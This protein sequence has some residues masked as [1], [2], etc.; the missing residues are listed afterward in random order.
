[1]ILILLPV[2][3]TVGAPSSEQA[4]VPLVARTPEPSEWP[5]VEGRWAFVQVTAA[6]S[7]APLLGQLTTET[8]ARGLVE[9][10]RSGQD[11]TLRE[12]VCGLETSSPTPFVRTTYPRPFQRAVSGNVRKGRLEREGDRIWLKLP[13]AWTTKGADLGRHDTLP[14]DPAD[15]RLTDADGDGEPGLTVRIDG[16]VSGEV[17]VV[18]RGWTSARLRV[19]PDRLEGPLTWSTKQRVLTVSNRL[20]FHQPTTAPH[21][22]PKRSWFRMLRLPPGSTCRD[23]EALPDTW[24]TL[25]PTP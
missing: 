2:A 12:T 7:D 16:L 8:R 24:T 15:P 22:D 21:P 3:L 11:L 10:A 1:M 6:V 17:R 23:L 25:P 19:A 5:R 18:T 13:R 9:V 20:L 4:R 14:D